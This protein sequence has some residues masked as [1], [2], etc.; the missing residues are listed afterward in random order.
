M[1]RI[2]GVDP[3]ISGALALVDT[4]NCTLAVMDMPTDAATKSRQLASG[5][6]IAEA[7]RRGEIDH[8][9]CE[10]VGVKPGEGAV[11]AFS[12]GRGFG[13]IEGVL[14]GALVPYSLVRPQEWKRR[15]G[16]PADKKQSVTRAKQLF[17]S[18]AAAGAFSGPRGGLKDG[19]AESA[20]IALYGTMKLGFQLAG[21]LMLVD[22]P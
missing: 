4:V 12:F 16:A 19:R 2:L 3:G 21:P 11:G 15:I 20:M 6:D 17:P 5:L 7:I 10:E 9:F 14:A 18:A 22:W 13:R 8:A 1:S